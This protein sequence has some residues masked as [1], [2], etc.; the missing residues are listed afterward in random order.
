MTLGFIKQKHSLAGFSFSGW[1]GTESRLGVSRMTL[2]VDERVLLFRLVVILFVIKERQLYK[3]MIAGF[4]YCS[5][6]DFVFQ[7]CKSLRFTRRTLPNITW[8]WAWACL[9]DSHL[10]QWTPALFYTGSSKK[11]STLLVGGWR[12]RLLVADGGRVS[13]PGDFELKNRCIAPK[14][15][16]CT[17]FWRTVNRWNWNDRLASQL[18]S[19]KT[20]ELN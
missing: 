19:S 12:C 6:A 3:L 4:V 15:G 16:T 11:R 10:H 2:L 20:A 9:I 17:H 18:P 1:K 5:F 14:I 7:S 8:S 13:I